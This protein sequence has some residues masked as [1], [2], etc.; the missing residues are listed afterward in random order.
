MDAASSGNM[1]LY[2]PLD[3]AITVGNGDAPP[4]TEAALVIGFE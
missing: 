3:T 4:I 1:L 2:G